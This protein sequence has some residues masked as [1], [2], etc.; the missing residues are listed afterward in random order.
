[1]ERTQEKIQPLPPKLHVLDSTVNVHS[2][3]LDKGTSKA[4]N[5]GYS[6]ESSHENSGYVRS[7]HEVFI[8]RKSEP[9]HSHLQAQYY[10][11]TAM[12]NLPYL[13]MDPRAQSN[14]LYTYN[15][16]MVGFHGVPGGYSQRIP[17]GEETGRD[18]R[19]SHPT[20]PERYESS[21][22]REP[23]EPIRTESVIKIA[24]EKKGD[25]ADDQKSK[26]SEDFRSSER[27]GDADRGSR[28][29]PDSRAMS[30]EGR[31][32][33]SY[34][35]SPSETSPYSRGYPPTTHRSY[36][37]QSTDP[38]VSSKSE[39]SWADHSR[40]PSEHSRLGSENPHSVS[41]NSRVVSTA[42]IFSSMPKLTPI[43]PRGPSGSY[44]AGAPDVSHRGSPLGSPWRVP[45]LSYAGPRPDYPPSSLETVSL[46]RGA[47]EKAS[48]DMTERHAHRPTYGARAFDKEDAMAARESYEK[49]ARATY[50]SHALGERTSEMH[51][52]YYQAH[53]HTRVPPAPEKRTDR[54]VKD[55]K[56][57]E[58]TRMLP[59]ESTRGAS[60]PERFSTKHTK[61]S[62]VSGKVDKHE[63]TNSGHKDQDTII[64]ISNSYNRNEKPVLPDNVRYKLGDDK[65][66]ALKSDKVTVYPKQGMAYVVS[67]RESSQKVSDYFTNGTRTEIPAKP[68]VKKPEAAYRSKQGPESSRKPEMADMKSRRDAE[69]PVS[70]S[71][72]HKRFTETLNKEKQSGPT[73]D[74]KKSNDKNNNASFDMY[75]G[76]YHGDRSRNRITL[77]QDKVFVPPNATFQMFVKREQ[78]MERVRAEYSRDSKEPARES[79]NLSN[80][81]RKSTQ[82]ESSNV[83]EARNV[84]DSRN[85]HSESRVSDAESRNPHAES[86]NPRSE[87]RSPRSES[88]IPYADSRITHNETRNAHTESHN[89]NIESR[90]PQN[91][92]RNRYSESRN[93]SRYIPTESRSH[94]NESRGH[95]SESGSVQ[96]KDKEKE[97]ST[98]ASVEDAKRPVVRTNPKT[99]ERRVESSDDDELKVIEEKTDEKSGNR[100]SRTEENRPSSPL[101]PNRQQRIVSPPSGRN[102]A[103]SSPYAHYGTGFPGRPGSDVT[104]REGLDQRL[105][106]ANSMAAYQNAAGLYGAMQYPQIAAHILN[107]GGIPLDPYAMYRGP[108]MMDPSMQGLAQDPVTGSIMMMPDAYLALLNPM[109]AS[110]SPYMMD[111]AML[112]RFYAMQQAQMDDPR[113]QQFYQLMSQQQKHLHEQQYK[114]DIM[115]QQ[116]AAMA[117]SPF[118]HL[119]Q[120]QVEVQ[121]KDERERRESGEQRSKSREEQTN[122]NEKSEQKDDG[123]GSAESKPLQ[124]RPKDKEATNEQSRSRDSETT[125][126][127]IENGNRDERTVDERNDK[128]YQFQQ[129]LLQGGFANSRFPFTNLPPP[130]DPPRNSSDVPRDLSRVSRESTTDLGSIAS[131]ATTDGQQIAASS[132]AEQRLVPQVT[133]DHERREITSR[134]DPVTTPSLVYPLARSITAGIP[135]ANHPYDVTNAG[136]MRTQHVASDAESTQQQL[137]ERKRSGSLSPLLVAEVEKLH[138]DDE[139]EVVRVGSGEGGTYSDQLHDHSQG[140]ELLMS[141]AGERHPGP[142]E[143]PSNRSEIFWTEDSGAEEDLEIRTIN[144]S[145]RP[146]VR[147]FDLHDKE[148]SLKHSLDS[149][150][151]EEERKRIRENIDRLRKI[152]KR[153]TREERFMFF[154]RSKELRSP[155]SIVSNVTASINEMLEMNVLEKDIRMRLADL[156]KKYR[157]KNRE[158]ARLQPRNKDGNGDGNGKH[159]PVKRGPGRPRKR[160]YFGAS[161]RSGKSTPALN[162][163]FYD[164]TR[165]ERS[166]PISRSQSPGM[167]SVTSEE[168]LGSKDFYEPERKR[169]RKRKHVQNVPEKI[170][171]ESECY[172]KESDR[173]TGLLPSPPLILSRSEIEELNI[174]RGKSKKSLQDEI[175]K[176]IKT[177][178]KRPDRTKSPPTITHHPASSAMSTLISAIA[179]SGFEDT[180]SIDSESLALSLSSSQSHKPKKSK[181]EKKKKSKS[182]IDTED[183]EDNTIQDGNPRSSSQ[184]SPKLKPKKV[185]TGKKKK[186]SSTESFPSVPTKFEFPDVKTFMDENTTS[187][188]PQ[189]PAAMETV[190]KEED[191]VF[192]AYRGGGALD[193]LADYASSAEK[194]KR[195]EGSPT[196]LEKVKRKSKPKKPFPGFPVETERDAEPMA[197]KKKK[198]KKKSSQPENE[199]PSKKASP[200]LEQPAAEPAIKPEQRTEP[201]AEKPQEQT[202]PSPVVQTEVETTLENME[203]EKEQEQK[204]MEDQDT[205]RDSES[206]PPSSG[207]K[208]RRTKSRSSS[209]KDDLSPFLVFG[210]WQPRRSERIFINSSVPITN[211]PDCSPLASPTAK[212]GDFNWPKK[213]KK[214]LKGKKSSKS[215]HS[216][217]EFG[218]EENESPSALKSVKLKKKSPSKAKK[219][220]TSSS[221]DP[222][223]VIR[224]PRRKAAKRGL[225]Y[226]EEEEEDDEGIE[227]PH[228]EDE[229]LDHELT[230]EHKYNEDTAEPP[231]ESEMDFD[232]TETTITPPDSGALKD[233]TLEIEE[234]VEANKEEKSSEVKKEK[235]RRRKSKKED[236]KEK[237]TT[238]GSASG[239]G[240]GETKLNDSSV[241]SDVSLKEEKTMLVELTTVDQVKEETPVDVAVVTSPVAHPECSEE[242]VKDNDEIMFEIPEKAEEA[243]KS[244]EAVAM[245]EDAELSQT[246]IGYSQEK[247]A[248]ESTEEEDSI[249][250]TPEEP[251]FT[252]TKEELKNNTQMLLPVDRLFFRGHI[253]FYQ[254]PDLFGIV[255]N[256]ERGRRPHLRSTDQLLTQAVKDIEPLSVASLPVGTRVCAHWSPQYRC[257]YPGNVIEAPPDEKEQPG[258]V[259]IEFDDGDSGIFPLDEIRRITTEFAVGV[260][261]VESDVIAP[262]R[263]PPSP[264]PSSKKKDEPS[265]KSK[266]DSAYRSTTEEASGNESAENVPTRRQKGRA[267]RRGRLSTRE[268]H[269]SEA[270]DSDGPRDNHESDFEETV[271]KKETSKSDFEKVDG[272]NIKEQ[273]RERRAKSKDASYGSDDAENNSDHV[274]SARPNRVRASTESKRADEETEPEDAP[275]VITRPRGRPSR[276]NSDLDL[277]KRSLT[278]SLTNSSTRARSVGGDSPSQ[279]DDDS[280]SCSDAFDD[281][282]QAEMKV[283]QP[284]LG[285]RRRSELDRLRQDLKSSGQLW[286]WSGKGTQN[287]RKG[288]GRKSFYKSIARGDETI[289]V[290]ECA[291]FTSNP[292]KSHNLP[293][294]GKIESMW[295]GW[296]GCMVVKVRW[297]YHPEE[298]KQGRRPGD[299]QNSLYRSTHVDENEIQTISHKCEVVSPEDYKER[300]TSQDTMATRSSSNERF[301]RLFCCTGSYDPSTEKIDPL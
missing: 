66:G 157:E 108:H 224:T 99:L 176:P 230:D 57:S 88:R 208:E 124:M 298:T 53:G 79:R 44:P 34:E 264:S 39:Y 238:L 198:K 112:Q 121:R 175:V 216:D 285:K 85:P 228:A 94:P 187:S 77:S 200:P 156:Q 162:G 278:W 240:G 132:T 103:R 185:K 152:A 81:S 102:S 293:Y 141:L 61:D 268:R 123:N 140:M 125:P 167:R 212:P 42:G 272:N 89:P 193:I 258:K 184:E 5:K 243:D 169:K 205:E 137:T 231:K 160:K 281:S 259:W 283:F 75:Y 105:Y 83:H 35:G 291:V 171:K 173:D 63:K 60:P 73:N 56:D 22:D 214:S 203:Q 64:R 211:N 247:D 288:K 139:L 135:P 86:R 294:V 126:T 177:K 109:V 263:R 155:T 206:T 279:D 31:K 96:S 220:R 280:G 189:Q 256:G 101:Y 129:Y 95:L 30:N 194:R 235:K 219:R 87:S 136:A 1:M 29:K 45:Y 113:W 17:N 242:K 182:S 98:G 26:I 92:P 144:S 110:E 37:E 209:L 178:T 215:S 207:G 245:K 24:T 158:L 40:P 229:I 122:Q 9:M 20:Q 183:I 170:D 2:A 301:G 295:E 12:M 213:N 190:A 254:E 46:H 197:K 55:G 76:G 270:T 54:H 117:N 284:R 262:E 118:Y 127:V 74:S 296:N 151:S 59:T 47:L 253:Q 67:V 249:D 150:K 130:R 191:E 133:T 97:V 218:E 120:K 287:K 225:N 204:G 153:R 290:G 161:T 186:K 15:S 11:P 107:A 297:Y 257:F 51:P 62:E 13:S 226:E 248:S 234:K 201:E 237:P 68:D 16:P 236:D 90:L 241:V 251:P 292:S 227:H 181:K 119:Y 275:L 138:Q 149:V 115:M 164:A 277:R 276:S 255:L 91:D 7:S 159:T 179:P 210:D 273:K 142:L 50:Y 192:V 18:G 252:F 116:Q 114:H 221:T 217:L 166:T 104:G 202:K 260:E 3:S 33:R 274:S 223:F 32:S 27:N 128:A 82:G 49:Q 244:E 233:K 168:N 199:S 267:K 25:S 239:G 195:P 48:G 80:E 14:L 271:L 70:Y 19:Q 131:G 65:K 282:P 38:R 43:A 93:D 265:F 188:M 250:E 246:K 180:S 174:K 196:K 163:S 299:V 300:V 232:A 36:S 145:F 28:D 100:Q 78:E 21:R 71:D 154:T 4:P 222:D 8:G 41:E 147:E 148:N 10:H 6:A 58:D 111:P 52:G 106:Q 165:S 172:D 23:K 84:Q 269:L 134:E 289:S 261:G 146:L 72:Y 143:S 286:Q 69:G 266:D